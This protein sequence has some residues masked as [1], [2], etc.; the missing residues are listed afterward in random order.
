MFA[1]PL[2]LSPLSGGA[3]PGNLQAL[4]QGVFQPAQPFFQGITGGMSPFPQQGFPLGAVQQNPQGMPG[5]PQPLPQQGIGQAGYLPIS[6]GMAPPGFIQQTQPGF[7]GR[8][9]Q[10]QQGMAQPGYPQSPPFVGQTGAP[11][12]GGYDIAR[13]VGRGQPDV[14]RSRIGPK[15]Y[16]RSDERI[17]ELICERLTQDM[18]I[19]VSEVGVDVQG[20]RVSL[21]GT[22]PERQMKHA[23]EDV[24]DN[25]WGVQDIENNIHVR[26]GQG[27]GMVGAMAVGQQGRPIA[28]AG[29][30]FASST[31][32]TSGGKSAETPK[33]G[34]SKEDPGG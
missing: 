26:S 31:V 4:Q 16:A 27:A 23:I 1:Q 33:G 13:L 5:Y 30:G 29:G 15:N 28:Q 18:S 12:P 17:R 14:P 2:P 20:A 22:V 19:D 6:Q 8:S 11:F 9:E 10:I 32:A 34:R 25:C 7:P 3:S 21:S 24:V